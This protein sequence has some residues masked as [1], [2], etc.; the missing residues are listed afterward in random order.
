MKLEQKQKIQTLPLLTA[1][2]KQPPA[3]LEKYGGRTYPA[4]TCGQSRVAALYS[5]KTAA[6]RICYP[7][8][9]GQDLRR[10]KIK[11]TE[12][13]NAQNFR[14]MQSQSDD[15]RNSETKCPEEDWK[16]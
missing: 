14:K 15:S 10:E 2:D 13:R 4:A 3:Y 11:K 8:K 5:K 7:G 1:N 16:H 9:C 6:A 12:P